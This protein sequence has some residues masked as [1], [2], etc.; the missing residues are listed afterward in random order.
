M[1]ENITKGQLKFAVLLTFNLTK[2][3]FYKDLINV[4]KIYKLTERKKKGEVKLFSFYYQR[5]KT[6]FWF[7]LF[8][9]L[10]TGAISKYFHSHPLWEVILNAV[11]G[12]ICLGIFLRLMFRKQTEDSSNKI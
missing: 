3:F 2:K 9:A 10:E 12:L 5:Y 7:I 6:W 11:L 4:G 1:A 8:L